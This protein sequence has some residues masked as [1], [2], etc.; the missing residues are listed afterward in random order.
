MRAKTLYRV[1]GRLRLLRDAA[2]AS[3]AQAHPRGP[4]EWSIRL[5]DDAELQALNR[6]FRGMDKPTDVLSFGGGRYRNG[7]PRAGPSA[8]AGDG[9]AEYLGDIVI[10]MD[11]C[12]AQAVAGGHGVDEELALLVVQI[13]SVTH[14]LKSAAFLIIWFT[15]IW[16]ALRWKSWAM[17][18]RRT[19]TGSE[20]RLVT[21]VT[22]A[23]HP[24]RPG[25]A[26]QGVSGRWLG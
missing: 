9:D 8:P 18:S 22:S 13:L 17:G 11:R 1:P 7:R 20:A 15:M 24:S 2:R 4:C 14:M 6:Q 25:R 10:S 5:T 23:A 26:P 12:A 3:L 21:D 19:G 16:L